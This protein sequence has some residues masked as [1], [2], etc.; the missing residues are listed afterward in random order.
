MER[1]EQQVKLDSIALQ[2]QRNAMMLQ[3]EIYG[4]EGAAMVEAA[5]HA[6]CLYLFGGASEKINSST[7]CW[8]SARLSAAVVQSCGATEEAFVAQRSL[9]LWRPRKRGPELEVI[10]HIVICS[11]CPTY[12]CARSMLAIYRPGNTSYT[13]DLR[14]LLPWNFRY[15]YDCSVRFFKIPIK[16]ITS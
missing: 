1:Q 7:V 8:R 6:K 15:N 16:K 14:P 11:F 12:L 2:T 3:Q 9:E 13:L 5:K 4:K 10:L